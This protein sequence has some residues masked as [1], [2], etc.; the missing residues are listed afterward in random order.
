MSNDQKA[1]KERDN[2]NLLELVCQLH[3]RSIINPQSEEIHNA[4][5]EARMELKNRLSAQPPANAKGEEKGDDRKQAIADLL[6]NNCYIH[7]TAD[8]YIFRNDD[9]EMVSAIIAG[10]AS[11]PPCRGAGE[12]VGGS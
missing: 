4:Y 8:E 12:V 10:A 7:S 6:K 1:L 2:L 3:S 5:T 11:Q 9:I